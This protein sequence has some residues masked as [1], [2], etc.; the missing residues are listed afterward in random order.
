MLTALQQSTFMTSISLTG[1]NR[2]NQPVRLRREARLPILVQSEFQ[3][4][5]GKPDPGKK[6]AKEKAP[7][8]V[9]L[10]TDRVGDGPGTFDTG[11]DLFE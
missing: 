4:E 2:Q 10:H 3:E 5:A 7:H 1:D 6:A 9:I 8:T 11:R